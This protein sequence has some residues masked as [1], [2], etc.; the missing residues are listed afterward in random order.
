VTSIDVDKR[1]FSLSV[2]ELTDDPW[3]SVQAR[4][5]LGQRVKGRVVNQED[6][7]VFVE[8]ED[9]IEGLVHQT[10][11]LQAKQKKD[12]NW[13]EAYQVDTEIM[14]EIRRIDG[15]DRKISLA[16]VTSKDEGDG[17]ENFIVSGSEQNTSVNDIFGD[18]KGRLSGEDPS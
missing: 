10:E 15:H 18:L 14:V 2:K 11:L 17:V 13:K 8:I 4:Y 6:F 5:F 16:E 9:G 1:R 12:G 3:L 7:G